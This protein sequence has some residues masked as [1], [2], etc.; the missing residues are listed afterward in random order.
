MLVACRACCSAWL[1]RSLLTGVPAG[2]GAMPLE[3]SDLIKDR[4]RKKKK[5]SN[6][7][8]SVRNNAFA[9]FF[10]V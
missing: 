7:V 9:F 3:G 1:K 6:D 5:T 2:M 4:M 8:G 10:N